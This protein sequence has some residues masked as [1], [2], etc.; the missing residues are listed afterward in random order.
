VWTGLA[1]ST[2]DFLGCL[3]ARQEEE[4]QVVDPVLDELGAVSADGIATLADDDAEGF[5][6]AVD[7]FWRALDQLGHAIAMP[8]LSEEHR[9]L[10]RIAV[11]CG[12]RYK[13]SGAG[14]GD[15]GVGFAIDADAVAELRS[16]AEAGGFRVLELALDESG[17]MSSS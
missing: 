15:F 13:P 2:G 9:A 8:I 11:D 17:L 10:R 7:A 4:P 16:R 5:L 12:V 3:R 14:G 6:H 1:A